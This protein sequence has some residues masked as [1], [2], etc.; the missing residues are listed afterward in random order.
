MRARQKQIE[1][2]RASI[3]ATA[4]TDYEYQ[5]IAKAIYWY[6]QG[7]HVNNMS[8]DDI[9]SGLMKRVINTHNLGNGF[10]DYATIQF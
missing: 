2:Q 7:V 10:V 8:I 1:T 4:E 5:A 6:N 9:S 3:R